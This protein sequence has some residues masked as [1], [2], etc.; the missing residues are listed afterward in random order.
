M[1]KEAIVSAKAPA[2]LG[3]YSSAVKAG[4]TL[5]LS[6]QLG[7]DPVTGELAEGVEAQARQAMRNIA[8]VVNQ[9]WTDVQHIHEGDFDGAVS[10]ATGTA[11]VD[12]PYAYTGTWSH[13]WNRQCG[14]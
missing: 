9:F 6:G 5:Y 8:G 1:G 4:N 11:R 12:D 3:P 14:A 7:I 10:Q 13:R 2:A